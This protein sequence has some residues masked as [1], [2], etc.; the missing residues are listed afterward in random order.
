MMNPTDATLASLSVLNIQDGLK[1]GRQFGSKDLYD[2]H[3]RSK[4]FYFDFSWMFQRL[5]VTTN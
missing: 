4:T 2:Q 5:N 1:D 3:T